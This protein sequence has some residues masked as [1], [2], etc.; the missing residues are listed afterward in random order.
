[1]IINLLSPEH[2]WLRQ[3][4]ELAGHL[5]LIPEFIDER[6]IKRA[7]TDW[8][9]VC[10]EALAGYTYLSGCIEE[11]AEEQRNPFELI[12]TVLDLDHPQYHNPI[13]ALRQFSQNIINDLPD[14]SGAP[15]KAARQVRNYLIVRIL[16][17]TGLRSRNIRELTY[18][19]DNTGH[20]QRK[21]DKWVVVIPWQSFKNKYSSFFGAKKKKHNYEREL[22]DRDGLYAWIEE[23]IATH[24]PILLKNTQS[25]IFFVCRGKTPMFKPSKFHQ[26]YR[27]LTMI[28]FA[29]N[30][31]LN[32]GI[33]GIKPH[34]PHAVRDML[35]TFIIQQTGSY[36]LAAY[37]IGDA[38][39]TVREHYARFMPKDKMRLPDVL[40]DNAWDN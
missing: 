32:R 39:R 33:P 38:L 1:M 31:Y 40:I 18:R 9:G 17:V 14:P 23:Y 13:S 34:G 8:D 5:K 24:R 28:Y 30:P 19:E 20:L 25:D 37:V 7:Q 16:S 22:H 3:K 35:A 2:G 36:E 12:L 29:H 21:G 4:P 11:V 10:D 15:I 26:M 27:K 6:F